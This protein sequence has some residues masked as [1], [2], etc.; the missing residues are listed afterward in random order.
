M[1]THDIDLCLGMEN[2]GTSITVKCCDTGVNIRAH[3][4][5]CR[6][7]KWRDTHEPYIIPEGCTPVIKIAKP[8]K[9]F[10]VKDGIVQGDGVLFET[11]PQ[12]FTA[13]GIAK[14]EVSLF[15]DNGERITTATF[16]INI[17]AEC[18]SKCEGESGDY[19]DVMSAQIRVA[20][21]AADRAEDA[22][23]RAENATDP[24]EIDRIVNEY[25]AENPPA[26][27]PAGPQGEKGEPGEQGPKGEKGDPG[28]DGKEGAT[29]APGKDGQ[30]GKDGEDGA[31]GYTPQ[32]GIDYYTDADKAEMVAAV[33]AALPNGDEVAY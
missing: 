21:E 9:T 18:T 19:V 10:F 32:K 15:A 11:K 28:A 27:G 33:L 1:I 3:L 31:D 20:I 2:Q 8:D 13:A 30:N 22:A 12:A 25:L 14:A 6:L 23:K 16:T 17:P 4:F 5:V 29:G 7:G 26:T 24:A